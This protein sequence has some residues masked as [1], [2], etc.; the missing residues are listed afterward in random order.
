MVNMFLEKVDQGKIIIFGQIISRTDLRS[1]NVSLVHDTNDH[2]N[3]I[4]LYFDLKKEILIPDNQDF[5]VDGITVETDHN[6]KIVSINKEV[7][8]VGT[9][10]LK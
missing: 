7:Y 8:P 6:G 2:T 9:V 5:Y 1:S 10:D 3:S 4:R